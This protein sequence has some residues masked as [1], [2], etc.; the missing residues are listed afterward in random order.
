MSKIP[1]VYAA[2]AGSTTD[3]AAQDRARPVAPCASKEMTR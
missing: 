1:V 2:R 3:V